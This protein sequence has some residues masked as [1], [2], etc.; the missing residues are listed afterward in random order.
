VQAFAGALE[1]T[2]TAENRPVRADN[3]L[4]GFVALI[5]A[6]LGFRWKIVFDPNDFSGSRLGGIG[7]SRR[8]RVLQGGGNF[9]RLFLKF[10]DRSVK[11]TELLLL[12]SS[13]QPQSRRREQ[14]VSVH[15]LFGDVVEDRENLVKFLLQNGIELVI[16]TD[17]APHGQSEPVAGSGF[18][19]IHRVTD[20]EF[21]VDRAAFAGRDVAAIVTRSDL[22]LASWIRQ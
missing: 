5:D 19:T 7:H 16:M 22:L 4:V 11:D 13:W 3:P 14:R 21:L 12:F 8:I 9:L 2:F 10:V 15:R 1:R 20:L 6:D 18:D 17:R